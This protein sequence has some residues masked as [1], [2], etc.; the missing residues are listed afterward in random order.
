MKIEKIFDDLMKK[1]I[2][3]RSGIGKKFE[4]LTHDQVSKNISRLKEEI[5]YLQQLLNLEWTP[6]P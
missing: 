4:K 5:L 2:I 6:L 3:V 1:N